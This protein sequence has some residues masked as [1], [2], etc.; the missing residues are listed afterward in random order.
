V[1]QGWVTQGDVIVVSFIKASMGDTRGRESH[2]DVIVVSF[3]KA[4]MGGHMGTHG[5]SGLTYYLT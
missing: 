2:G 4:S 5:G 1:T 3:I